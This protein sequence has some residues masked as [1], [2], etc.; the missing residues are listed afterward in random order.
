MQAFLDLAFSGVNLIPTV[1]LLFI[2]V[3]WLIVI[4]GVID[5]D[6]LDIDFEAEVEVI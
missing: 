6:T 5:I 2:I 4:I 1:L 3:Y